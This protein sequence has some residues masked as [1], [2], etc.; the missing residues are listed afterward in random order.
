[1]VYHHDSDCIVVAA[2]PVLKCPW[3]VL[4]A[5]YERSVKLVCHVLSGSPVTD[6]GISWDGRQRLRP[7]TRSDWPPGV[8]FDRDDEYMAYLRQVSL[9]RHSTRLAAKIY[10]LLHCVPKNIPDIFDCNLK[11]NSQILIIFGMNI[12]DTTFH[13]TTVQFSISPKICFCTT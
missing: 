2:P 7:T 13:Q 1:L 3:S 5:V 11:T 10:S 4:A 6:A 9:Y 12:F 8:K